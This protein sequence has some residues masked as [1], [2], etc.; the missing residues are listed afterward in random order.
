MPV[1]GYLSE[2]LSPRIHDL[3]FL[4]LWA[5]ILMPFFNKAHRVAPLMVFCFYDIETGVDDTIQ[6]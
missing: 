1:F 4:F 6:Q 3:S 2:T 5:S